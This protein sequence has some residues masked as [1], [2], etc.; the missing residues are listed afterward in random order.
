MPRTLFGTSGIRGSAKTLF[1][2]QFCLEVGVVFGK[3]LKT[4]NKTGYVAVAMDPRESSPFIKD[5]VC[6][7]LASEGFEIL[8]EGVIPTPALTYFVKQSQHVAGGVMVTGS[9][10]T[11][12]LNGVK[13]LV[14][15]GEVS[16][17]QEKEIE[18]L[19]GQIQAVG[20]NPIVK[21]ENAARDLYIDLLTGM[22]DLPYPNWKIV[23][24]TANGTQTEVIPLLAQ[25]LGL[26]FDSDNDIQSD[27]FV[28]R[29]TEESNSVSEVSKK[30][31]QTKSDLGVAF[32]VD[33]D[34]VV[35]VAANGEFVP[36][37]YSCTL[38]AKNFSGPIITTV[39]TADIIEA[40][41]TA[42]GST[43]VVAKMQ[44][45]GSKFGFEPN[46]GGIFAA[47]FYGR[48]GGATL[49]AMLNILKKTKLSLVDNL[50][51]LPKFYLY[52]D[53]I[54]C[55]FDKYQTI[56]DAVK[57]SFADKKIDST[58]GLKVTLGV[59]EWILFRGSGNA[60]EFRVF[61]QS[62]DAK[63]SKVLGQKYLAWVEGISATKNQVHY[64][65]QT[66]ADTLGVE[67]TINE[68]P[69]QLTQVLQD[70]STLKIDGSLGLVDNIVLAGMG[71][72]ALGGRVV[73]GF[74]QA[75][76]LPF[77]VVTGYDL[78]KY[79]SEKTLVI[80]SSYSGNTAEVLSCAAQA[81]A[82]H[83]K[84]FSIATGGKLADMG[85]EGYIFDPKY[86][87]AGMPRMG[88]GYSIFAVLTLLLRLGLIS[89]FSSIEGLAK[90]LKDQ[91][92]T[93]RSEAKKLTTE[94]EN[95]HAIFLAAGH[96]IGAAHVTKNNLNENAKQIA[97][98][99]DLPEADHHL[100]EGLSFPT[101]LATDSCFILFNSDLYSP[102]LHKQI[103][104]TAEVIAKRHLK[105]VQVAAVGEDVLQQVFYCLHLGQ[106]L[107]FYLSQAYRIDPGPIPWVDYIKEH[108]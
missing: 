8:D 3:W 34:R 91:Q 37:D 83:A 59:G 5:Y 60:P 76:K 41:R 58:D 48:D 2:K 40:E 102:V 43:Q 38:I 50:N 42:V 77:E 19:F 49:I 92:G 53:K 46:G 22:A 105:L 26:S 57:T 100:L 30:V 65:N 36:G 62:P 90:W 78:P 52:K 25:R 54:K 96:L 33:G 101:T 99:F 9:H 87:P 94:L 66:G 74:K 16:K 31:L 82:V 21:L 73:G 32:D 15:A 67:E 29:D 104:V 97:Y 71:G 81:T 72:S 98:L 107:S 64:Q 14:G 89:N 61:V 6:R 13:L 1:T 86:D 88:V 79:V 51:T 44:E 20:T 23:V 7:G 70:F 103:A 45:V 4:Q 69:D 55:P 108:L 28:P 18:A 12:D 63:K 80:L 68:L 85:I 95:R 24:D 47:N 56:L 84:M 39:T 35:F 106:Y 93:I 75:V 11:A 27:Y 17:L 10:I